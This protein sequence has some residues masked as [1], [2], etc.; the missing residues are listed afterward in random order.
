MSFCM[1]GDG[2]MVRMQSHLET[3]DWMKMHVKPPMHLQNTQVTLSF[4]IMRNINY[5]W[6]VDLLLLVPLLLTYSSIVP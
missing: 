5:A 6:R 2:T 3:T 4:C 1:S